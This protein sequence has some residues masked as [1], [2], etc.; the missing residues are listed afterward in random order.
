MSLEDELSS[1]PLPQH[2]SPTSVESDSDSVSSA[3]STGPCRE[4]GRVSF[5]LEM[6]KS[7]FDTSP[8][9]QALLDANLR[10]VAVN[11]EFT[12]IVE[13]RTD[14][15]LGQPVTSVFPGLTIPRP[16][17][18]TSTHLTSHSPIDLEIDLPPSGTPRK[19]KATL[20]LQSIELTASERLFHLTLM[21]SDRASIIASRR[22]VKQAD[23]A[24]RD[25][26]VSA[27]IVER[28]LGITDVALAHIDLNDLL[29]ELLGRIRDVLGTDEASILLIDPGEESLS[30]RVSLGP[31]QLVRSPVRVQIGAGFVGR[32]AATREP[33]RLDDTSTFQFSNPRMVKRGVRSLMGVPML[34]DDRLL[35]VVH[36]GSRTPRHFTES[37]LH[38]LELA[39]ARIALAVDRAN[40][41]EAERVARA[42]AERAQR[43]NEFLAKASEILSSSLDRQ[44]TLGAL[45]RFAVPEV[46]DLCTI[47]LIDPDGMVRVVAAAAT[48][49]FDS[50]V[51]DKGKLH[52]RRI[53]DCPSVREIIQSGVPLFLEQATDEFRQQI[54][55]SPEHLE[56]L[57]EFDTASVMR[58]PL[59]VGGRVIGILTLWADGVDRRFQQEDLTLAEDLAHRAALASDNAQHYEEAQGAIGARDEFISIASHELKTPLTTVKGYVQLLRRHLHSDQVDD[60]RVNRTLGQL[61]DQVSRFEE[62]I[63]ELLDVSRIQSDRIRLNYEECDL[64]YLVS[65]IVERVSQA[66]EQDSPH[67][68]DISALEPAWGVWDASRLDQVI[69]NLVS[70]AFKYSPVGSHVRVELRQLVDWVELDVTDHGIGIPQSEHDLVFQPFTRG[71]GASDV[72]AGAGLGLYISNEIV[73]RHG[74]T[75]TFQSKTG[76][77]T[78]FVVRLPRRPAPG[79]AFG[80]Q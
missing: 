23:A 64:A 22:A 30:L 39:A 1:K 51:P 48:P 80:E 26:E 65:Q 36:V 40:L 34:L 42:V 50:L 56:R 9:G 77:Q 59:K 29:R 17:S 18:T 75:L 55:I 7:A 33:I 66:Y 10:L 63:D 62:L 72:A 5:P 2:E 38:L 58:V 71:R 3:V 12:R 32:I 41:F 47:N 57:R 43:R 31:D 25:A 53:A 37:D 4:L 35:G 20:R 45:A 49:R 70:N 74:G 73:Q 16:P 8:I 21:L 54:A 60:E 52:P 15:L 67:S 46:A 13:Q 79:A 6:F 44:A 19:P 24:R 78:T 61:Q 11:Q 14:V 27:D 28:I 76:L 69:T 68:V